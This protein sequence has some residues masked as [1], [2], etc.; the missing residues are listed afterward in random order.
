MKLRNEGK[1]CKRELDVLQIIKSEDIGGAETML[2]GLLKYLGQRCQ[3]GVVVVGKSPLAILLQEQG[4]RT[5]QIPRYSNKMDM[6]FLLRLIFLLIRLRPRLIQSHIIYMNLYASLCGK[7]LGIPVISTFH[8]CHLIE[9]TLERIMIKVICDCSKKVVMVSHHQQKHFNLQKNRKVVVIQNGIDLLAVEENTRHLMSLQ[10]R[11]ELKLAEADFVIICVGNLRPIKGQIFLLK[12][13]GLLPGIENLKL[14]LVGD[15]PSKT[16]LLE[17]CRTL[18]I[19]D[20]V[21]FLGFREDVSDL[22][23]AA[24]I[25]VS[26]SLSEATSLAIMEAMAAVKPIIASSVGDNGELI[27]D[28]K[29]GMLVV[30]ESPHALAMAIE[31]MVQNRAV[32]FQMG[33]HARKRVLERF[34]AEIMARNYFELY[35][36]LLSFQI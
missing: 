10:K 19:I 23:Y 6:R 2:L 3:V 12:A 27:E 24:D 30:A 29:D 22:L 33:V 35:E 31:F 26:P 25:F 34:S 7:A 32:A 14:L 21:Q 8:S 5:W 9:T 1:F 16:S 15:G 13:I 17:T 18:G 11:R 20:K 36:K 4:Y 28:G